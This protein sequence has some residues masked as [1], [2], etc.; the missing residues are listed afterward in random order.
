[1]KVNRSTSV[2][3]SADGEPTTVRPPF[4]IDEF[5]RQS[6]RTTV[7]PPPGLPS[8]APGI[9]SGTMEAL[10]PPRAATVPDLLVSLEDLEW[11]DLPPLARRII[12]HVDGSARID[13][14]CSTVGGAID[15]ALIV[16]EQLARD[17]L[18]TYR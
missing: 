3:L 1:M 13:E 18:L 17:G 12:D 5:A 14:I 10:V 15:E 8:Y 11:F 2:S 6:E 4:D 16:V 7:P 9:A